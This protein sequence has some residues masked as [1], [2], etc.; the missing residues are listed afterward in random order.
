MLNLFFHFL[1]L[2]LGSFLIF[3]LSLSFSYIFL[4]ERKQQIAPSLRAND[5]L[6]LSDDKNL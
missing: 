5:I 1:F 6:I 2:F 3:F 4:L